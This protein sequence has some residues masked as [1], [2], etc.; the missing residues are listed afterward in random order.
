MDEFY[1]KLFAT[2]VIPVNQSNGQWELLFVSKVIPF[3]MSHPYPVCKK[4]A[5]R[6][7][8]AIWIGVIQKTIQQKISLY[9]AQSYI[10][11]RG[12]I[13][14]PD[15]E[16]GEIFFLGGGSFNKLHND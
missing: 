1:H 10:A 4:D 12:I 14:S 9:M 5:M 16:E 3:L 2:N 13:N 6:R 11:C 7:S 15:F 8:A